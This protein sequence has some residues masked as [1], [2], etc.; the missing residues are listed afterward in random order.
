M[1]TELRLN[2]LFHLLWRRRFVIAAIG[3]VLVIGLFALVKQM[4][5]TYSAQGL[6]QIQPSPFVIPE[7]RGAVATPADDLAKPR[8]RSPRPARTG[9]R[10]ISA[11]S[12]P[13]GRR[14]RCRGG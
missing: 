6:L 10:P 9:P 2:E 7:D 14:C 11:G 8:R 12:R 1:G 13:A 5:E 3:L 4:P